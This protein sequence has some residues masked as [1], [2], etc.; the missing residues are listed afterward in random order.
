[1]SARPQARILPPAPDGW[2]YMR[3]ASGHWLC[4]PS[5]DAPKWEWLAVVIQHR[6]WARNLDPPKGE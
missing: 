3:A 2:R 5:H 4:S 6:E 1:M